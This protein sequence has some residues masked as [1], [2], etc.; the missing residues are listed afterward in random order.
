MGPDDAGLGPGVGGQDPVVADGSPEVRAAARQ[1]EHGRAPVA[2]ADCRDAF[3]IDIGPGRDCVEPG[4]DSL[5]LLL[6]VGEVLGKGAPGV[7]DRSPFEMSAVHVRA[8]GHVTQFGEVPRDGLVDL[9]GDPERAVHHEDGRRGF[10]CVG[11]G[12]IPAQERSFVLEL[13]VLHAV[14]HESPV[15][16]G[17]RPPGL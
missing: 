16:R 1:L 17:S 9:V 13:D 4:D 11:Q 10:R 8:D 2:E 14:E 7:L 6:G 15:A 12:G 5:A 3:V